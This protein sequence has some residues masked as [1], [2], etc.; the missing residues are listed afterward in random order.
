MQWLMTLEIEQDMIAVCRLVNI[1]RR[2]GLK[3]V[4]LAMASRPASFSVMAVADSPEGDVEH[5]FNY[6]RRTEGVQ[7]VAYYR[8]EPSEDAA[9]FFI[10]DDTETSRVADVLNTFPGSKLVFA[11][12]GKYLLEVPAES[13]RTT[14]LRTFHVP[15]YLPF[16]CVKTTRGA[17]RPE[18]APARA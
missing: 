17:V 8:H 1:F 15:E 10:D 2:K 9:F 18:L 7:H 16:A 14:G 13:R 12:N 11:S 4:T 3:L 6:L 5:I